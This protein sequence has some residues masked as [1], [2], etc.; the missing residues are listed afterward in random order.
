MKSKIK[1]TSFTLHV[2]A[3]VFM[4][5][6]HLWATIIPGNEWLT[7]VGRLAFP[8][9]AFLIVE[10]YFHTHDFKQYLK[11]LF[12]FALISEIPFNLML[13]GG[14]FYPFHQNVLWTFLI[15]LLMIH[16]NENAAPQNKVFVAGAS[17][18]LSTVGTIAMVD[19]YHYGILTVLI[20]Y[21]CRGKKWWNYLGQFIF[22]FYLNFKMMGG[23]VYEWGSIIFPQQGFAILS[24]IPI[25]LYNGEQ[26]LYNKTIK[27]IY[28]WFYP[29]HLLILA[30]IGILLTNNNNVI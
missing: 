1:I 13:C 12:V 11:R 28:Y 27:N 22:M 7:C 14:I 23:L 24:L 16:W 20:F 26:G 5:C 2:L 21:F 3:M 10:G 30:I 25:W 4:L 8:I 18:V 6:D 19:Y 9:F 29:Y 17:I 15:A